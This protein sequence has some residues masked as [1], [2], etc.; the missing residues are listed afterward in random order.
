VI[1]RDITERRRYEQRLQHLADHDPLTGLLNRRRFQSE[2]RREVSR[3]R[4]S[5]ESLTVLSVDLDTFKGINDSVGHAA[6]DTVLSAVATTLAEHLRESDVL[7]R[8]GGDEFAVVLPG[9]GMEAATAAARHLLEALHRCKIEIEGT[10]FRVTASIGGA[11]GTGASADAE[12]LVVSADLAMYAAKEQG[13][14]R[15]VIFSPEEARRARANAQV[16]W[17]QRIRHALEHE[18]LLLH[19]QAIVDLHRDATSHGELLLRMRTGRELLPPASFLRAAERLG[20]I[21]AIDRWVVTT[22]IRLLAAGKGPARLPLSANL[23]AESVAGDLDL[24]RLIDRDLSETGVDPSM[25]IFDVTETAAIANIAEARAFAS[26]LKDLGCRLAL[27]DF[28]TGFGS[29]YHLK[30]LPVD[31][32]KIDREFVQNLPRSEVD[33]RLVRAIV[34]VANSLEITTV[35]ESVGDE[36]TVDL[37]RELGVDYVQGFHVARPVP[38]DLPAG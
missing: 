18:G 29:F 23:S 30:H 24:L 12:E 27:D 14:D 34:D 4:R 28:G 11:V 33:Q 1:A 22:A 32:I 13:G 37:L 17:S 19:W 35:A 25:L 8:F 6:G 38:I 9:A 21:H 10:P 26:G 7:A 16:G 5:G 3:V 31:F 20:L 2:L 15:T 36:H